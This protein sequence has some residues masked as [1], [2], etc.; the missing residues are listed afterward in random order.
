MT[1]FGIFPGSFHTFHVAF[2][3]SRLRHRPNRLFSIKLAVTDP[4]HPDSADL[5]ENA[6]DGL[7]KFVFVAGANQGLVALIES[8]QRSVESGQ[9]V[10]GLFAL[11]G[12]EQSTD[13]PHH[14]AAVRGPDRFT[15]ALHKP[16]GTIRTDDTVFEIVKLSLVDDSVVTLHCVFP[17]F[18]MNEALDELLARQRAARWIKS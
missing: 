13:Q 7:Q 14:G 9:A 17:I 4:R 6:A 8:L 12:I 16:H 15:H 18:G 5:N 3:V 11:G 10:F 2:V 1:S